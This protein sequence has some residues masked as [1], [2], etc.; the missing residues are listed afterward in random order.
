MRTPVSSGWILNQLKNQ[1]QQIDAI[2]QELGGGA[3]SRLDALEAQIATLQTS[4][5]DTLNGTIKNPTVFQAANKQGKPVMSMV[6]STRTL[7]ELIDE[8]RYLN[9]TIGSAT[10]TG[11]SPMP[12]RECWYNFIY[13]P[14]RTGGD[15]GQA[16]GD[17]HQFGNL[18]L[19]PMNDANADS[20]Y[21]VNVISGNM[22]TPRKYTRSA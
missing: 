10:I 2:N 16:A 13:I 8:L 15:Y 3:G 4:K 18:L 11:V 14:H 12:T 5:V 7:Q 21:Q 6:S 1:Q 9:G 19:F 20:W 22:L 17:N